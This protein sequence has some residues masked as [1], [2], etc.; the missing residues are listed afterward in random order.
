MKATHEQ[1]FCLIRSHICKIEGQSG[2]KRR[3]LV[4]LS[5]TNWKI[6]HHNNRNDIH[7][8]YKENFKEFRFVFQQITLNSYS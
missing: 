8:F 2:S 6:F 1:S 5:R 4:A 7:S 3:L